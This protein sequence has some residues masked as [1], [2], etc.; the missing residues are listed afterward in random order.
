VSASSPPLRLVPDQCGRRFHPLGQ[1]RCVL[2]FQ[3]VVFIFREWRHPPI[4]QQID[5][6]RE[7]LR[8]QT[9]QGWSGGIFA[10]QSEIEQLPD[11]QG[12]SEVGVE[13]GVEEGAT[14]PTLYNP[15]ERANAELQMYNRVF[16]TG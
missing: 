2:G 3:S 12:V 4:R 6:G 11:L 1:V 5:W 9:S 8:E 15:C 10:S 7:I 13:G 16:R 14:T